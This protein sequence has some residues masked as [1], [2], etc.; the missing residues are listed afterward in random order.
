MIK[1]VRKLELRE[2]ITLIYDEETPLFLGIK[3]GDYVENFAQEDVN[4]IKTFVTTAATKI[5]SEDH[6]LRNSK[7]LD[8]PK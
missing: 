1:E 4:K 8:K 2:H 5:K 6:R 3:I 7:L